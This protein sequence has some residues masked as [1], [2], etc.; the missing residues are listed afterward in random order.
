MSTITPIEAN[1]NWAINKERLNDKNLNGHEILLNQF[2]NGV[3][4]YK[5]AL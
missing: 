4:K 5:I 1:L 2:N 3:E